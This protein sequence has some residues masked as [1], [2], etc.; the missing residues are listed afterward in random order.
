MRIVYSCDR[1][2]RGSLC[3][4]HSRVDGGGGGSIVTCREASQLNKECHCIDLIASPAPSSHTRYTS[5]AMAEATQLPLPNTLSLQ[6]RVNWT[7]DSLH[8]KHRQNGTVK[9]ALN[10]PQSGRARMAN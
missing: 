6:G 7:Q 10:P 8:C 9:A 2:G 1:K 4:Q 3:M 5:T